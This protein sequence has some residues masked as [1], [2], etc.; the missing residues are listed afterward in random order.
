M[1]RVLSVYVR[2]RMVLRGVLTPASARRIS[3]LP[4]DF[5][6]T[7][8]MHLTAA[9]FSPA[10]TPNAL[11]AGHL[12]Q[13]I[14]DSAPV[15]G[16]GMILAPYMASPLLDTPELHMSS[17]VKKRKKKMNKHKWKKRR[18]LVRYKNKP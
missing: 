9:R 11:D 5:H 12:Q 10:I 1:I 18:R 14:F 4:R 6:A 7:S 15:S 8:I 17:I 3:D 2:Q 16:S 13:L